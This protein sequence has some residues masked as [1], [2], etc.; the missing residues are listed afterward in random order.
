MATVVQ[1]RPVRRADEQPQ[2]VEEM[3]QFE[4]DSRFLAL[5]HDALLDKFPEQ[6]IAVF[7]GEVVAN[8][9]NI[10]DALRELARRKVPHSRVVLAFLTRRPKTLIL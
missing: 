3:R 5:H 2:L 4:Q 1:P 9:T 6:W 7:S 8:D 10:N